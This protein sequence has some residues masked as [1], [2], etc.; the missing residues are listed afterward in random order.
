MSKE[1]H[2]DRSAW[3]IRVPG[4]Y[5]LAAHLCEFV[6]LCAGCDAYALDLV[7]RGDPQCMIGP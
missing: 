3:S 5:R 6:D 2:D 7:G 1:R 4:G